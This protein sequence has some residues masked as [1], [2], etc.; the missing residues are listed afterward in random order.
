MA[1]SLL[2]SPLT[3]RSGRE[4]LFAVLLA[5]LLFCPA[6]LAQSPESAVPAIK[7]DQ[8]GYPLH[9]PKIALIDAAA[10]TFEVRRTSDHALVFHGKLPPAEAWS[11][12]R[13]TSKVW[14]AA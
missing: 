3:L 4:L 2:V 5:G 10:Q 13:L 7:V 6:L 14:A 8:V 1:S 12:V 11:L 9:G